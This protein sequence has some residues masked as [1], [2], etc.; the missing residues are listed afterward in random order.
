MG[1]DYEIRPLRLEDNRSEFTC[2]EPSLD[3]FFQHYAGQSQ[4]KLSLSVTYVAI[5]S[6]T[7][8][9]FA[10]VSAGTIERYEHPDSKLQKRLPGYPIPI[11]RLARL[12]VSTTFQGCGIG[13]ALL[14][15]VFLI[16][17]EQQAK[18][19]CLGVVSDAKPD[20]ISF[21]ERLGFIPLSGVREGRIH[22]DPL[23]MFLDV[24]LLK[25]ALEPE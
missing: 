24:R 19:G 13:R 7:V 18:I 6:T 8:L 17:V 11:L 16:A 21:Y 12:G 1:V 20:A 22:G 14:R 23:P 25:A 2:G 10:T 9:G 5:A 4:F 15:H 3:R